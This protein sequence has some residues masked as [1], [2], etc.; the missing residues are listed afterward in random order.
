MKKLL[1]SMMVLSSMLLATSYVPNGALSMG[2]TAFKTPEKKGVNGSFDKIMLSVPKKS[3][4]IESLLNH[5]TVIIDTKSVN[6]KHEARDKK[7][8]DFLFFIVKS[9][10][11]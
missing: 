10:G 2:W 7:L 9:R 1:L 3:K 8:T 11:Y 6:S 5:A 4:S